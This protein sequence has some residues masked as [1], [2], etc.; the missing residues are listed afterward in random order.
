MNRKALIYDIETLATNPFNCVL[1]SMAA[2]VFDIKT[3]ER[4][5]Y[6]YESLVELANFQKYNVEDQVKN[7]NRKIDPDTLD[8]WKEQGKE[9]I[10]KL[11]PSDE[12]VSITEAMRLLTSLI[13]EN[14]ID[15][16]FTRNNS[17]DPVIIRSISE[18]TGIPMPYGWWKIRD[19]KSFIMGL[20]Y[21]MNIRDDFIPPGLEG[22]FIKHDPRHDIAMDIMR[23]QTI[24]HAKM[25]D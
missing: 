18:A 1:V 2:L 16:V 12:D 19:T 24:L 8:W 21:E 13:V 25:S 5:E 7:Y 11:K 15:Y 4:A 20:T 17:F 10:K 3:L 6:D 9:A 22:K 23:L 14:N